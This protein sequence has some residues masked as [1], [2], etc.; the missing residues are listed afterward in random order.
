MF[1]GVV[2]IG[3]A[4]I[5][6]VGKEDEKKRRDNKPN[7]FIDESFCLTRNDGISAGTSCDRDDSP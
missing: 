7:G 1:R 4:G 5:L 6:R 2:K 3:T